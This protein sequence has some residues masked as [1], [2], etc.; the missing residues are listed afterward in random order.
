MVE[1]RS[2]DSPFPSVDAWESI[3]E[4]KTYVV[5]ATLSTDI[6]KKWGTRA[7]LRCGKQDC[8]GNACSMLVTRNKCLLAGNSHTIQSSSAE[9]LP[10]GVVPRLPFDASNI[11]SQNSNATLLPRTKVTSLCGLDIQPCPVFTL[12]R[13]IS[14]SSG[15]IPKLQIAK[16]AEILLSS[17]KQD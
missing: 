10:L 3:L 2:A 12:S 4:M 14:E 17:T 8:D 6:D 9:S 5:S 13:L 15:S 11:T 1:A 7:E 16:R